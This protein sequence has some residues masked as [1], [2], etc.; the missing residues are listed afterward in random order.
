MADIDMATGAIVAYAAVALT[1]L[2]IVYYVGMKDEKNSE[3]Q[4][5]RAAS[6]YERRANRSRR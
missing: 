1:A 5:V 3:Y 2:G 6:E 4:F